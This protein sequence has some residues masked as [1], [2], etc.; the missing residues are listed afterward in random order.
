MELIHLVGVLERGDLTLTSLQRRLGCQVTLEGLGTPR[1]RRGHCR[2]HLMIS[3][4][5]VA[6]TRSMRVAS[7]GVIVTLSRAPSFICATVTA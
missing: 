5:H 1:A 7:S 4:S 6:L 2:G 3:A